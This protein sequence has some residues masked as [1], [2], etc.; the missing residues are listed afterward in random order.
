[1]AR[2]PHLTRIGEEGLLRAAIRADSWS[3]QDPETRNPPWGRAG[4]PANRGR[5]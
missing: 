5:V 2:E 1:V 4:V 3:N